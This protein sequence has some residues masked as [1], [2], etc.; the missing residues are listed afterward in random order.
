MYLELTGTGGG[1][2]VV[3][4]NKKLYFIYNN[5]SGT[6]TV[7]VSGQTGVA[8]PTNAK[9][10]LV[11]NGTDVVIATNYQPALTLGA[12]LPVG[13]GGTGATTAS[14]AQSNL[15]VPS[16]TGAGASGTWGINISGNAATASTAS[17][18]ASGG[19]FITSSNI[20]SQSVNYANSAG[21]GGVTSV[22]GAT[23]AVNLA[24]LAAF[25]SNI[26]NSGYQKLPG[27][28]IIQWG[29][30]TAHT[31]GNNQCYAGSDS[32]SLTFPNACFFCMVG[33]YS[34]TAA[35]AM[36][37]AMHTTGFT[38][39]GYSYYIANP[40]NGTAGQTIT[41]LYIAFGY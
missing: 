26:N 29:F 4:A 20:G 22:N 9:V 10:S 14:G 5:T 31:I 23:G 8:V 3:P 39:G 41:P 27:G 6:V 30:G 11:C 40:N 37:C 24:S 15:N 1:T 7:K 17:S 34:P 18:P 16:T 36:V 33:S 35:N 32:F 2:L 38:T 19:S 25:A 21:N 28:V 12:A 13:S